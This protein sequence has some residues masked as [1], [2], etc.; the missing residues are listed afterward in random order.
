M[1]KD[2]SGNCEMRE[3]PPS[4]PSPALNSHLVLLLLFG[5]IPVLTL[6]TPP[7][8]NYETTVCLSYKE[9]AKYKA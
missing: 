2:P 6:L 4:P 7:G 8:F 1:E 9:Q 3:H 5:L